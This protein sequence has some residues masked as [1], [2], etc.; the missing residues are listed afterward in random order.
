MKS[1]LTVIL[2]ALSLTVAADAS[3]NSCTALLKNGRGY[4]LDTFN[5]WGYDRVDACNQARRQCQRAMRNGR[6][7]ARNLYCEVAGRHGG[8]YGQTVTRTCGAELVGPRGRTIQYFQAR[9]NGYRGSGVKQQACRKALR[10]CNRMKNEQGRYRAR[11][12]SERGGM[13]HPPVNP[14]RRGNGRGGR[15]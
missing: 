9:A 15:Y 10:K 7:N 2:F 5:A 13:S 3:A 14:P 11:C 6:H 1:L 8:G 4:T 12:L